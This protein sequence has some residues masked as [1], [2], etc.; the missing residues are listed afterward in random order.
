MKRFLTITVLLASCLC[1][2]TGC[3]CSDMGSSVLDK[4]LGEE[5]EI[6]TLKT[7]LV[8]AELSQVPTE[9]EPLTETQLPTETQPEP[10]TE[11]QSETEPAVDTHEILMAVLEGTKPVIDEWG[12]AVDLLEYMKTCHSATPDAYAFVD[13][14]HDGEDEMVVQSMQITVVL[15]CADEDVFVF[16]FATREMQSLKADGSFCASSGAAYS[17]ILTLRFNG[18][19]YV[20]QYEATSDYDNNYFEIGGVS[21]TMEKFDDFMMQWFSKRGVE[22]ITLQI[23]DVYTQTPYYLSIFVGEY[24]YDGPGYHNSLAMVLDESGT[25]TIVE[26]A[27]DSYGNIWGKLKSGVGWVNVTRIRANGN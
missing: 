12:T 5:K 24:I 23:A 26:E 6:E 9:T 17:D 3:C 20:L 15:H 14:D 18:G 25:F 1:F 2:L 19:R 10:E 22:W 13:F 16:D 4:L 21:C 7:E 8:E 27:M 11:T